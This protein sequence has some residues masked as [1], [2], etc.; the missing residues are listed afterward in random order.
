[1][2]PRPRIRDEVAAVAAE[3]EEIAADACGLIEVE[4]EELPTVFD[5]EAALRPGA[6]QIHARFPGNLVNFAYKFTAG[7]VDRAFRE[8]DVVVEGTYRLNYVTTAC[9]GTM[10][11]MAQ[12]DPRGNL[13]MWSTTQIPFLYQRDLA[14]ALG[15]S[16]DRIRV[17]QPPVGGNFGRG[18]DLYPIDIITA[19]LARHVQ[20]PVKIVFDREEEFVASPT[21]E[22]CVFTLRTAARAD[23]R[24]LARD[25]QV[26]IDNGA[27]VSWGST[28]PYVMMTT[29]AGFYRCRS[30]V[31]SIV[32]RHKPPPGLIARLME[33]VT[34]RGAQMAP[35]SARGRPITGGATPTARAT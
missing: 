18:L 17:I 22:P 13:T 27:Y 15:I 34:R 5:P 20:R 14:E 30:P 2:R 7:D 28:T 32:T 6:P 25:A 35:P 1:M 21:R 3:T 8:A 10:A 11:A 31:Q 23:G 9:I 29:L 16:G 33:S 4:Y 12:W 26:L 24:L 19:L